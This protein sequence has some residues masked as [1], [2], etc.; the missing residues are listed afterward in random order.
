VD[1]IVENIVEKMWMKNVENGKMWIK[2]TLIWGFFTPY[3]IF[4]QSF[5]KF[6]NTFLTVSNGTLPLLKMSFPTFTHRS[7]NT[8][9]VFINKEKRINF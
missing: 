9:T 7:T 2:K 4:E 8:T 3:E 5:K 1:K 6:L